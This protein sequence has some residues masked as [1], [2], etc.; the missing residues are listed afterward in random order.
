MIVYLCMWSMHTTR[1]PRLPMRDC[2]GSCNSGVPRRCKVSAIDVTANTFFERLYLVLELAPTGALS[3]L[4]VSS[5]TPTVHSTTLFRFPCNFFRRMAP[6]FCCQHDAP[7]NLAECRYPLYN[8]TLS[9]IK[10]YHGLMTHC[11]TVYM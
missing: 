2:A 9:I 5:H 11:I 3:Q 8:Q 10:L 4:S 1:V 7:S 6:R